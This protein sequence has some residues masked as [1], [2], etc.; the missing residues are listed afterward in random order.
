MEIE[1]LV[2]EA[3]KG[4]KTALEGVIVA[5]QDNIYYLAL[6]MLVNPEDAKDATQEILIKIITNLSEFRYE[7]HFNTWVYRVA[8]NYLISE[9]KVRERAT[10][11][12]FEIYKKD[13]E[14]DLQEPDDL[15]DNPQYHVLLNE[16]RISCTMAMLLCLNP[17][18]RMAYILGDIFEIDHNEASDILSISPANFRKQL[19]RARAKIVEFMSDSCGFVNNCAKCRCDKKL[20][21]A[22]SRNRV[23]ANNIIFSSKAQYSYDDVKVSLA[24]TQQDLK[25][26]AL[27][28][29]I[30]HYKCPIQLSK[31]IESLVVE[32]TKLTKRCT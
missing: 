18:Y 19:S 14:S 20:I 30:N 21:G 16:L 5:I 6:R 3:T 13:L 8:A 15:K 26:L 9:K 24:N 7:S 32:G 25:A 4:N 27:Q 2:A 10:G 29:S 28:K 22:T 12:T 11:L 17:V 31:V 1:K 23:D